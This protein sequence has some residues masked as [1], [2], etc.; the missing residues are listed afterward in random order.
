MFHYPALIQKIKN[1]QSAPPQRRDDDKSASY[2]RDTPGLIDEPFANLLDWGSSGNYFALAI[3][4]YLLLWEGDYL[5]NDA[6]G[7]ISVSDDEI[8]KGVKWS[9]DGL[10]LAIG[11]D[12][13]RLLIWSLI[14]ERLVS[15]FDE[16]NTTVRELAWRSTIDCTYSI[17]TDGV[18]GDCTVKFCDT[19]ERN[20]IGSLCGYWSPDGYSV[21]TAAPDD[22]FWV[23]SIVFGSP[24]QSGKKR[25]RELEPYADFSV[26]RIV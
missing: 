4:D 16:H 15:G 13:G 9:R 8:I 6:A 10:H 17:A 5:D 20:E 18:V 21:A 3:Q 7:V 26:F 2:E 23:W 24:T 11:T 14:E 1:S 25:K 19:P 22:A 12:H